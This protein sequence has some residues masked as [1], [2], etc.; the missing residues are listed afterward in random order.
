MH[1]DL[2]TYELAEG[3]S[4]DYLLEV[5]QKIIDDWMKALPGFIKWEIHENADGSFT[6]IVYWQ[7]AE[8][9][10]NAEA[11]MVNIPNANTWYACYKPGSIKGVALTLVASF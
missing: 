7:D 6:D 9:A 3:I 11:A 2:I 8:A 1:K 10:R 5:A 4:K